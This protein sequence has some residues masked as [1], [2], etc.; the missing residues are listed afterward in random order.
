M[1]VIKKSFHVKIYITSDLDFDSYVFS[2]DLLIVFNDEPSVLILFMKKKIISPF[3]NVIGS[4]ISTKPKI[5][6]AIYVYN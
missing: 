6:I 2:T 3:L 5:C 1:K 4:L